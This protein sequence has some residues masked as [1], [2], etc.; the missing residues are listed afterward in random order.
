M[1]QKSNVKSNFL[2]NCVYQILV[3]ILPLLTSPYVSRIL[4]SN[5]LGIFSYTFSMAST[6]ALVGMLG[7]NNYGNRTIAEVR[8]DRKKRSKEFWNIWAIQCIITFI[9]IIAYII[10]I[11][12]CCPKEYKLVSWIQILTILCSAIDIN[13]L[14]FGLEKFKITVTRNIIIKILSVLMIFSFVKNEEDVWLYSVIII[15]GMLISNIIIWPFLFKEV[16][17]VMPKIKNIIPHFKKTIILF[18]PVVAITL[19]NKIDKV[20]IGNLSTMVQTGLYENTEK[21]ITIPLSFITALGTVM[22]PRM[23]Y[24]FAKGNKDETLKYISISM[25]FVCFMAAAMTFG[26]AGISTEF[27]PIFFGE[28][29]VATGVLIMVLSP[30]IICIS[31]ANVLRTQYLIPLH[32]DKVYVVS[33]W[34]GAIVNLIVNLLLI[35]SLGAM[36]AVIGTIIAEAVVMIYQTILVWDELPILDYIKNGIY[37]FFGGAVMFLIIRVIGNKMGI[38]IL[39]IIVQIIVGAIVYLLIVLP[40]TYITHKEELNLNKFLKGKKIKKEEGFI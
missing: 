34:L 17:F 5:G 33:V 37:Y 39:T 18:V 21:I 23:S 29:F 12:F 40:Y 19:Y 15:G 22:L 27:A 25:E 10:Y 7:V 32:K 28:E 38:S 31:W 20:M 36:G 11:V 1:K 16:D 6:F 26:I 24:L 8:D 9:M 4:G 30:K 13:W 35:P 14:F 3:M 2:Y